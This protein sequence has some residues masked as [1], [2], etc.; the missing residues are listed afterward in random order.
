VSKEIA[1]I[2]YRNTLWYNHVEEAK[3]KDRQNWKN[4]CESNPEPLAPEFKKRISQVY[5]ACTNQITGRTWFDD[6][7]P[8]KD[9][10]KGIKADLRL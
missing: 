9:I 7:P 10:M 2:H 6:V 4:I 5:C 1:R 3:K 8:L